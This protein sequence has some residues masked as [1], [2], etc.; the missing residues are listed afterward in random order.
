M[1][2]QLGLNSLVPG[3][4]TT[5]FA[6]GQKAYLLRGLTI[7]RPNQVWCSDITSVSLRCGYLYLVAVT[8]WYSRHVLAWRLSNTLALSNAPAATLTWKPSKTNNHPETRLQR[9]L[10]VGYRGVEIPAPAVR[11][12]WKIQ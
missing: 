7:D 12:G 6:P 5:V 2:P 10:P 4:K 8:D 1:P 9:R 3:R 11:V